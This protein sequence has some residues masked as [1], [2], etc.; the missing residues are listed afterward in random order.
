MPF[1]SMV[2]L[3][4]DLDIQTRPSQRPDTS[5][6]RVWR[7]SVQRSPPLAEIFH[8]QTKRHRERQKQNLTQ[9]SAWVITSERSP[10]AVSSLH[11]PVLDSCSRAT[12]VAGGHRH[13]RVWNSWGR[14]GGSRRL[15]W[16]EE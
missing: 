3:T 6:L 4:F 15:D 8:T 16:V 2:T 7:K 14:R 12:A 11:A 13:K 1:L 9:F 10:V 5:S